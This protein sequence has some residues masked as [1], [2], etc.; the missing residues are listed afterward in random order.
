M[1]KAESEGEIGMGVVEV[2][3]AEMD[4]VTEAF[5]GTVLAGDSFSGWAGKCELSYFRFV[6]FFFFSC[7]NNLPPNKAHS[8]IHD[9]L[10]LFHGRR[11]QH[12]QT[13]LCIGAF[14]HDVDLQ[15]DLVPAG[16]L[17]IGRMVAGWSPPRG[18]SG[19]E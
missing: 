3:C 19:T 18:S 13:V 2:G 8:E 1:G 7:G 6:C 4:G 15:W 14:G 11:N 12:L 5:R 10:D 16:L 9:V 17:M